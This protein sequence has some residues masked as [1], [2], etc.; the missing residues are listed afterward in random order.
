MVE[1]EIANTE[2][3][4][5]SPFILGGWSVLFIV[6]SKITA[7]IAAGV[8]ISIDA[9]NLYDKPVTGHKK[10]GSKCFHL[11]PLIDNSAV[12]LYLLHYLIVIRANLRLP[13]WI[14]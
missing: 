7:T 11:D 8:S 1:T 10:S 14:T 9:V 2:A 3:G 13:T 4:Y 5:F 6:I 12:K